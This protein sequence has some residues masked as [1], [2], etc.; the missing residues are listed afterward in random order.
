MPGYVST[1]PVEVDLV[2]SLPLRR[3]L[4]AAVVANGSKQTTND[5]LYILSALSFDKPA[6]LWRPCE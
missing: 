1:F 6:S 5:S 4:A 2:S 3:L